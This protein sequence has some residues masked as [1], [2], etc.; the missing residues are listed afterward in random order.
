MLLF[1]WITLIYYIVMIII[2]A[3]FTERSHR[4]STEELNDPQTNKQNAKFEPDP[5]PVDPAPF[6]IEEHGSRYR[7]RT[8]DNCDIQHIL[9]VLDTS[10]SVGEDNFNRVTSVLSDLITLFCKPVKLAVMTF[11]H[12]YYMEFCFDQYDSTSQGR[13]SAGDA[14]RSIPYFRPHWSLD[15]TRWTH[16]A[17]A[18]QCVCNY[19]LS[20][21]CGLSPEAECVDVIFFTDGRAN[22]P[23]LDICEEI[24]C[25]HRRTGVDTF[26]LGVGSYDLLKME[27]YAENDLP[28]DNYHLFNFETFDELYEQF[29]LVLERLQQ[30]FAADSSS[31]Y[32]CADI[33]TDPTLPTETS[34]ST[35]GD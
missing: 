20:P 11:D 35:P 4:S 24:R 30:P 15:E 7:R 32:I 2:A 16:T 26:A 22:D 19:T 21:S 28:L 17:G 33:N 31:P 13:I 25:L 1:V 5:L 29:Q 12:E 9:L 10:G 27:C 6:K 23:A 8:K 18:V 3:C 14:V 34:T